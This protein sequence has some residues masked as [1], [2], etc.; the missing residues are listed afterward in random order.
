MQSTIR[1]FKIYYD[2]LP[3]LVPADVVDQM[4]KSLERMEKKSDATLEEVENTMIEFGYKVWPWQK[5]QKEFLARGQDEMAEHFLLP[6]LTAE[7]QEKY[8]KYRDLGMTM[9]DL[10]SGRPALEY[11]SSDERLALGTAMVD[12]WIDLDNYVDHQISGLEKEVFLNRVRELEEVLESIRIKLDLLKKMA[13]AESEH[14]SLAR[15]IHSRVR[16]FEQ[17]LCLLAPEIDHDE[18][19]RSVEF[20]QGRKKDLNRLRGINVPIEFKYSRE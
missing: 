1:I 9:S 20:F 4:K 15:E 8:A 2:K 14:V 16:S 5:A 3:P 13:D 19:S 11:F 10:Y 12:A 17:G 7:L 18:V 6:R